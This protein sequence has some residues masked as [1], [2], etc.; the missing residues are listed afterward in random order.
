MPRLTTLSNRL[1]STGSKKSPVI[2]K[3]YTGTDFSAFHSTWTFST[4]TISL[5]S[6]TLPYHSYG[7]PLEI[8]T[9]IDQMCNKTWPLRAGSTTSNSSYIY[10]VSVYVTAT[11]TASTATSLVFLTTATDNFLANTPIAF[12]STSGGVVV[13]ST[14]FIKDVN[15]TSNYFTISATSSGPEFFLKGS[16]TNFATILGITSASTNIGYWL[17]GV[18]MYDPGAGREAPNGYL[19]FNNLSYSA[20]YETSLNYSYTLN[21]DIAGGRIFDNGSYIYHNFSFATAWASGSG[22]YTF[23]PTPI[24][25][26]PGTTGYSP[27]SNSVTL[28]KADYSQELVDSLVGQ[29]TVIDRYP[30]PP[31]IYTVVSIVTDPLSP[32]EWRMTVDTTFD[33]AGQYKP[34][35]FY[36]DAGSIEIVTNDIWDTTGNSVG[37]KWVAWFK[38]N[39]PVNFE[40]TVQSGWT[41]NLAGLIWIVDYVIED[42]VNTNQWRIYV[43]RSLEAGV[44]IPIFSSPT[45]T[46]ATGTAEVSII[47]YLNNSLVQADGHSKILGWS[48]DGYPVYGPYGYNQ[49]LDVNSGVRI[50]IGGYTTYTKASDVSARVVDGALNLINYPL[51]IFVEDY[52]FEGNG[53]LDE[54][55]GRYCVTPEYPQGTYA[56]FC[57]IDPETL[58]PQ[59]PYVLGNVYRSPPV[60]SGQT[61]SNAS[62]GGGSAPKQTG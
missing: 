52:Y 27:T 10:D 12:S 26:G 6:S 49:P 25:V 31:L 51:G 1:T 41:I 32:T 48:L 47:P 19:T 28:S 53:D 9:A 45:R 3:T 34:I 59:Y 37:E 61:A 35:S 7:N 14:Y 15:T 50:M 8:T 46:L 54:C 39:L 11:S 38:T 18:N 4:G 16:G 20:A 55:N 29:T 23:T 43:T 57:T 30:N 36:P 13:G 33:P 56:Y 42:P 62:D 60:A 24:T 58:R 21:Q 22:T 5:R 2:I 40:T 17:N 44:G